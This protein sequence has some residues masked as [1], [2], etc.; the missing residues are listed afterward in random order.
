MYDVLKEADLFEGFSVDAILKLSAIAR[1][2]VLAAG[3]YLFLLGDTAECLYVVASGTVDLCLPMT[4]N[5]VV[6]DIPVESA[7]P[8]KALGWSALV[9]PYRFTLSA[10]AAQP[11]EVMSF[12]RA[13][14]QRLFEAAPELGNRLFSN[15]AELVG[16]RLLTVQALWVRELQRALESESL[17]RVEAR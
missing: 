11:A 3:E 17:H 16:L 15:L 7:T 9:K 8:G 10:R 5:G 4:L 1:W 2:R 13:E 6:K 12:A 14:L